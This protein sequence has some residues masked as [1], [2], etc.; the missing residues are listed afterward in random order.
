MLYLIIIKLLFMEM[1]LFE[2]EHQPFFYW[3]IGY[4]QKGH[5]YEIIQSMTIGGSS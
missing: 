4:T 5:R 1:V 2:Q 3:K